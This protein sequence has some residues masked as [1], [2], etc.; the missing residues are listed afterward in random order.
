MYL[1]GGI[2]ISRII[3][4]QDNGRIS[5]PIR[6]RGRFKF[7]A[8]VKRAMQEQ[9]AC[10][11]DSVL[12]ENKQ[13]QARLLDLTDTIKK[14]QL[15]H[16]CESRESVTSAD[17]NL[18]ASAARNDGVLMRADNQPIDCESFASL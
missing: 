10:E 18:T 4:A 6:T 2:G 15:W 12:T 17:R 8:P 16:P 11:E 14:G 13:G 9:Y 3:R 5:R 7:L 1:P